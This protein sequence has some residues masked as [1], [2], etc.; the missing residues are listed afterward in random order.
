[1]VRAL[2]KDRN[3]YEGIDGDL[4]VSPGPSWTHQRA[5]QRLALRLISYLDRNPV[6][7]LLTGP[8]DI[9]FNHETLVE[10]DLFVVPLV[11]GK[12]PG[13]WEDVKS[14]L[15]VIEVLSPS[16]ARTDRL[17]KRQLYLRE[18]A[19]EY[20]VVDV[21]SRL[22]QRWTAGR[23]GPEIVDGHLRWRPND[24]AAEIVLVLDDYLAE[25]LDR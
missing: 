11:D 2:P 22:I 19:P 20:W 10:P 7:D 15:L 25:V 21:D 3:R 23:D 17:R 8:G 6:G 16:S 1:M 18:G 14:L 24:L 9:Q 12:A 5:V 13:R 4:I